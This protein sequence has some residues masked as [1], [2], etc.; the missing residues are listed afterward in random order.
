MLCYGHSIEKNQMVESKE[1]T[2]F[3][4]IN[5][6]FGLISDRTPP[7]SK[8]ER[9]KERKKLLQVLIIIKKIY[10]IST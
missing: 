7:F 6:E 4:G 1:M 3:L 9:K 10:N 2:I 8:K 5:K